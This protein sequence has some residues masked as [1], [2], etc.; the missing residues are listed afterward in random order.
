MKDLNSLLSE[1]MQQ[2][3]Q[4]R[5][6]TLADKNLA[7]PSV[8]GLFKTTPLSEGETFELH[9]ILYE[10]KT[11]SSDLESD[12]LTLKALTQEI[13]AIQTQAVIL[14]GE[15]IKKAQ[16]LL[17]PY[18]DGAFTEWLIA[19]YGNRQTPYNFLQF[20]E[21]YSTIA[22]G[23]RPKLLDMPKQAV[24]TLASRSGDSKKKVEII[25][26]YQ[27]EPKHL[28]LAK[29]RNAFPLANH[30]KRKQ[31]FSEHVMLSLAR[32]LAQ[33][34]EKDWKPTKSERNKIELLLKA[35]KKR[36]NV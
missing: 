33:S 36:I 25:Q 23:L 24:Y 20:F 34:E 27:G 31:K 4:T 32:I 19:V 13:K 21:F 15:R 30:D 2:K 3:N 26:T 14:H 6:Q 1:K 10:N 16:A 9:K 22:E 8:T 7:T 11:A 35:L 18:K 29:I 17:K 5:I 28:I 12:L